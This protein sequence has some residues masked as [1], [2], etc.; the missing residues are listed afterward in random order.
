MA[1][2]FLTAL[3]LE[4][5]AD[6]WL[7][8]AP[9]RYR[10]AVVD[11]VIEVPVG[12]LT[13]LA[14]VPRVPFLFWAAGGAA[15]GPAVLHDWLCQSHPPG[16]SWVQAAAVFLEAMSLDG[17]P[18][19]RA[20]LMWLGVRIAGA[21]AWDSGPARRRVLERV[22]AGEAGKHPPTPGARP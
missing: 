4:R 19:W 9:L 11:A 7:V 18:G 20:R 5:H 22:W 21:A 17:T 8:L 13:D 3:R 14:S 10:S 12:F 1:A 15:P 16:V 2:A 6:V